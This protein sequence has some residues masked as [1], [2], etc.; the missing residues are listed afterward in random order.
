VGVKE[1]AHR[2]QKVLGGITAL[3]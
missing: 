1:F 2:M 3:P